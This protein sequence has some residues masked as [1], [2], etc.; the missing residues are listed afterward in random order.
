VNRGNPSAPSKV[1]GNVAVSG[2]IFTIFSALARFRSS[3]PVGG[4]LAIPQK[5]QVHFDEAS[6]CALIANRPKFILLLL[7]GMISYGPIVRPIHFNAKARLAWSL[8]QQ[9]ARFMVESRQ[10][11]CIAPIDTMLGPVECMRSIAI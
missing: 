5:M 3:W 9:D 6:S 7:R 8:R 1:A 11:G 4:S 10:F 2:A